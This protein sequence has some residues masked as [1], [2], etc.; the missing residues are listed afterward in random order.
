MRAENDE[1]QLLISEETQEFLRRALWTDRYA[2]LRIP[3]DQRPQAFLA[4]VLTSASPDLQPRI[5]KALVN[6]VREWRRDEPS[7]VLSSVL[8]LLARVRCAEALPY[9][10]QLFRRKLAGVPDERRLK[11]ECLRFLAGMGA[12]EANVSLFR[13]HLRD[14]DFAPV[15]FRALYKHDIRNA[16]VDMPQLVRVLTEADM[17]QDLTNILRLLAANYCSYSDLVTIIDEAYR[18]HT[19]ADFLSCVEALPRAGVKVGPAPPY[20]C[21]CDALLVLSEHHRVSPPEVRASLIRIRR[22][23]RYRLRRL[24]D[25]LEPSS[26]I[27]ERDLA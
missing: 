24:L 17:R 22:F 25:T 20:L 27:L 8:Y 1:S 13:F 23:D 19:I 15:C 6:L 14:P 21:A 2:P 26:G 3:N 16:G 7:N 4:K 11:N 18:R 5:R 12:T 10:E 9:V